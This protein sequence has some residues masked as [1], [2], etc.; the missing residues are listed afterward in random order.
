MF[1]DLHEEDSPQKDVAVKR[2]LKLDETLSDGKDWV[3]Q[4]GKANKKK[5]FVYDTMA[6]KIWV[7]RSDR[8]IILFWNFILP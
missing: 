2:V 8:N 7:G 1:S 4:N 6:K 3:D 5:V